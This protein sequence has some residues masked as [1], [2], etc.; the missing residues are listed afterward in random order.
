[1]YIY[2]LYSRNL[3]SQFYLQWKI[4]IFN[5]KI[6]FK[7]RLPSSTLL[8]LLNLY[9]AYIVSSDSNS[10]MYW[11]R[12]L[13]FLGFTLGLSIA[14]RCSA[15]ID[16][17][18]HQQHSHSVVGTISTSLM[19]HSYSYN[20]LRAWSLLSSYWI[21]TCEPRACCQ[22]APFENKMAFVGPD[23]HSGL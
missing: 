9:E 20:P 14:P 1:M 13:H 5:W 21:A 18:W 10:C 8:L 12:W 2:N 22:K 6:F 23:G 16:P 3:Y 15:G 4:R 7:P 11:S 17:R 19:T